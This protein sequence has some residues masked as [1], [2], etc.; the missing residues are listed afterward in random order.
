MTAPARRDIRPEPRTT[1]LVRAPLVFGGARFTRTAT[2]HMPAAPG[3]G[4]LTHG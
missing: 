1:R 3:T 2:A 4:V